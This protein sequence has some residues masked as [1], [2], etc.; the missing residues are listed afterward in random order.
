[1]ERG[2]F[3]SYEVTLTGKGN[4]AIT[5]ATNKMRFFLD[6]V[7]VVNPNY[8]PTSTAIREVNT[9]TVKTG[10]IYTLDGR[11]AGNVSSLLRPGLYVVDG[12]KVVIK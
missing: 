3:T 2:A 6:E 4:V 10:R 8:D 7:M 11:F 9:T 1:M 12:K 5:F